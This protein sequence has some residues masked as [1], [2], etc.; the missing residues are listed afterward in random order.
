M[1]FF[2]KSQHIYEK[3]IQDRYI[4]IKHG[5]THLHKLNATGSFLWKQLEN[6]RTEEE[7]IDSLMKRYKIDKGT[8]KKDVKD[9]LEYLLREKLIEQTS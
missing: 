3:K 4:L 6:K 9:F 1:N 2:Y 5:N 7:L 8:A